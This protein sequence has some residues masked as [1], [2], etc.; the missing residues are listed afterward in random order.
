MTAEH[1]TLFRRGVAVRLS[2]VRRVPGAK[3]KQPPARLLLEC[4]IPRFWLIL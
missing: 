2:E 4:G 3:L 1:L